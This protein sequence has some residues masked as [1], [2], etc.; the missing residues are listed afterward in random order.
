MTNTAARDASFT[1]A[2]ASKVAPVAA[3]SLHHDF[4]D[5]GRAM[6]KHYPAIDWRSWAER[7][8]FDSTTGEWI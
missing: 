8:S 4:R 3:A 1:L 5:D 2:E 7:S 6:E